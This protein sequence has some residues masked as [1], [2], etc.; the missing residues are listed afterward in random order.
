MLKY[1][2]LASFGRMLVLFLIFSFTNKFVYTFFFVYVN[3][4]SIVFPFFDFYK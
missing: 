1:V 3:F 2:Q 4:I